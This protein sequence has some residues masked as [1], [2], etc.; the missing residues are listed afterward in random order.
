MKSKNS[1]EDT[2]FFCGAPADLDQNPDEKIVTVLGQ[3]VCKKCQKE[4]G[5]EMAHAM[6]MKQPKIKRPKELKEYLDRFVVGQEDAKKTLCVA[7][8]NHYKRLGLKDPSIKKSNVLMIGPTGSGKTYLV[9]LLAKYLDIPMVV[10]DV[11]GITKSGYVGEST[12]SI[13][14]RLMIAAGSQEKA[15]KGIIVLDEVD[16]LAWKKGTASG[17]DIGG[18]SVQ[19]EL[20]KMLEGTKVQLEDINGREKPV[21]FCTDSV[22]FICAGAFPGMEEIIA[23]RIGAGG[24]T[25]GF[26]AP[27]QEGTESQTE[28]L[29]QLQTE[30]LRQYGLISE[31]IGRLPVRI[32]LKEL[33]VD[34]LIRVIRDAQDSI[35]TQYQKLL[36]ADDID[37]EF[38]DAAVRKVA[39]LA[40]EQHT[41]A[42][43]IRSIMEA[44]ML[45]TMFEMPG[46]GTDKVIMD[47]TMI[48]LYP[49]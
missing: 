36:K 19:Q 16:K 40:Y 3:R 32:S 31:F 37:L 4:I 20:L 5:M 2:C 35:M 30:D 12:S 46:S 7:V 10:V 13:L 28:L 11:T 21:L 45:E 24:T 42:R 15:E 27:V 26:A 17:Q 22:L 6:K 49:R 44:S 38:T 34:E 47:E 23:K 1:S 9:E 41:G 33:S 18:E 43:G 39:E 14:T 25:L 29:K 8:Y 48:C